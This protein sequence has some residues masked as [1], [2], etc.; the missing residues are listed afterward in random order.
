M[1]SFE[2]KVGSRYLSVLF[3]QQ[4]GSELVQSKYYGFTSDD[5]ILSH[6]ENRNR[7][8]HCFLRQEYGDGDKEAIEII[9][10]FGNLFVDNMDK[11]LVF[12]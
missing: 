12:K 5:L 9:R 3:K 1:A 6:D 10:K 2:F 4:R 7:T 11:Y 8:S